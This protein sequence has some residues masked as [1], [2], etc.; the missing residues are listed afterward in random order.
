MNVC[1][2]GR[3]VSVSGN[4]RHRSHPCMQIVNT[5]VVWKMALCH[6]LDL[7]NCEAFSVERPG[8]YAGLRGKP[9]PCGSEDGQPAFLVS[10]SIQN[11]GMKTEG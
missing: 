6:I 1:P 7:D 2:E 5:K 11:I 4:R 3:H 10:I 9:T 8:R